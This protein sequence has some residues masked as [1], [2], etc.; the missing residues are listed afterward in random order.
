VS[1][2][3][4]RVNQALSPVLVAL[5]PDRPLMPD[6]RRITIRRQSGGGPLQ[7]PRLYRCGLGGAGTALAGCL[8][9]DSTGGMITSSCREAIWARYGLAVLAFGFADPGWY[10]NLHRSQLVEK[11]CIVE[12]LSA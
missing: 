12:A 10:T 4:S 3:D 11:L 5:R 9:V 7:L 6:R 2:A 8:S 1:R